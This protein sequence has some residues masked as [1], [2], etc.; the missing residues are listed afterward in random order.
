MAA[1]PNWTTVLPATIAG[2]SPPGM[3]SGSG[4]IRSQNASA[5][6]HAT[7]QTP[8]IHSPAFGCIGFF[9]FLFT[10]MMTPPGSLPSG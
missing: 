1:R 4:T 2:T 9:V 7:P 3:S 8:E 6:H 10:V 5:P